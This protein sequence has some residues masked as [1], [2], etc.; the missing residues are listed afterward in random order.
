MSNNDNAVLYKKAN[1]GV[2]LTKQSVACCTDGRE[3]WPRNIKYNSILM[4]LIADKG[5]YNSIK[6]YVNIDK[7]ITNKDKG[8]QYI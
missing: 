6:Q 2:I 7:K 8:F 4:Q 3:Y 1:W 5:T